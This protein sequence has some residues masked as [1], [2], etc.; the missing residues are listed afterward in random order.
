M[1]RLM[2]FQP[3]QPQPLT[4]AI[5][6]QSQTHQKQYDLIDMANKKPFEFLDPFPSLD[7]DSDLSRMKNEAN[8]RS[9]DVKEDI[10]NEMCHML[11]LKA[12]NW[13]KMM[14]H[15]RSRVGSDLDHLDP[16]AKT[17]SLEIYAA[18]YEGV[19]VAGNVHSYGTKEGHNNDGGDSGG[20]DGKDNHPPATP[21]RRQ[22]M[23][24]GLSDMY[25]EMMV[26]PSHE[27]IKAA[28]EGY[29]TVKTKTASAEDSDY[30][31]SSVADDKGHYLDKK[32]QNEKNPLPHHHLFE[33]KTKKNELIAL[34][35]K[36]E[37]PLSKKAKAIKS[38]T[39]AAT[40]TPTT[41]TSATT[42]T[43]AAPSHRGSQAAIELKFKLLKAVQS[44]LNEIA[45]NN[46]LRGV[47]NDGL[48]YYPARVARVQLPARPAIEPFELE[49]KLLLKYS[50]AMIK[51]PLRYDKWKYFRCPSGGTQKL[52]R[53]LLTKSSQILFRHV[54]WYVYVKRYQKVN[55]RPPTRTLHALAQII[56]ASYS[57]LI[58]NIKTKNHSLKDFLFT[59]LPF[60]L[61]YGVC[62]M[63]HYLLPSTRNVYSTI[64]WKTGVWL[65][66]C[67]LLSGI[68]WSSDTID[69]LRYALFNERNLT[70]EEEELQQEDGKEGE[71]NGTNGGGGSGGGGGTNGG[72]TT[73][74]DATNTEI[75]VPI[76]QTS[77]D[78]ELYGMKESASRGSDWKKVKDSNT[79]DEIRGK[80]PR[81]RFYAG[82]PSPV[83][84]LVVSG[85]P[86]VTS[87][88]KRSQTIENCPVGG[89]RT[90]V[91]LNMGVTIRSVKD[92]MNSSVQRR[93]NY[94]QARIFNRDKLFQD[95]K[96][97]DERTESLLSGNE[98]YSRFVADLPRIRKEEHQKREKAANEKKHAEWMAKK[99]KDTHGSSG[100][101]KTKGKGKMGVMTTKKEQK[102]QEWLKEE[103]RETI[104]L[105][106][107]ERKKKI[108]EVVR[109]NEQK[110]RNGGGN[111]EE[112][113]EKK[114]VVVKRIDPDTIFRLLKLHYK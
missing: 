100:G 87:V 86:K 64:G 66:I 103:K 61:S 41:A 54:F 21:E 108:A 91:P 27:T 95:K 83:C 52:Q 107:L 82:S 88:L 111:R 32:K 8:N 70:A 59:M 3:R 60:S 11:K 79:N 39:S 48:I 78:Y 35:K 49:I 84:S 4:P 42:P 47:P 90:Y 77:L 76:D 5:L 97:I 55:H 29:E 112:D 110:R 19:E 26:S 75:E 25:P 109:E 20:T 7:E 93:E 67:G 38:S 94:E 22:T 99:N 24:N 17:K 18:R 31:R 113:E 68:A 28:I 51:L 80:Q 63:F 96:A 102:K 33:S 89:S 34:A 104:R 1:P 46:V 9:I 15:V 53:F 65:D 23:V 98:D 72:S 106:M 45:A 14:R 40:T 16:L 6:S 62:S 85:G 81:L 71:G 105:N 37:A 73:H 44:Q 92:L 58:S 36:N 74:D 101:Q 69:D 2:K 43:T 13:S 30:R 56:G 57:S 50:A 10:S 12:E 114:K